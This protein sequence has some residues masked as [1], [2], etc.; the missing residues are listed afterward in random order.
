MAY[1]QQTAGL[2]S[3]CVKVERIDWRSVSGRGGGDRAYPH[4]RFAG[5]AQSTAAA[6]PWIRGGSRP[7]PIDDPQAEAWLAARCVTVWYRPGREDL[8][9]PNKPVL[10]FTSPG[11]FGQWMLGLLAL[12]LAGRALAEWRE[13]R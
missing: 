9:T 8:A 1:L 5:A 2:K 7:R 4:Y 3:A 13:G 11:G 10:P 6:E 12:V